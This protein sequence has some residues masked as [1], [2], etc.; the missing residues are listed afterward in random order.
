MTRLVLFIERSTV[1]REQRG[2]KSSILSIPGSG[3]AEQAAV[4]CDPQD[5]F[6]WK[7]E[8]ARGAG[9][10][11]QQRNRPVRGCH[12]SQATCRN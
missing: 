2:Q 10:Q 6:R 11:R 8:P 1:D 9:D 7:P 12:A 5:V 4:T 3:I